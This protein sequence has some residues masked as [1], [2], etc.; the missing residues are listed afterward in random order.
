MKIVLSL[1]LLTVPI[2]A[3][4]GCP[5]RC[6]DVQ[7]ELEFPCDFYVALGQCNDDIMK[8]EVG[9]FA[10]CFCSC[11]RCVA[12][13]TVPPRPEPI[14]TFATVAAG[15]GNSAVAAGSAVSTSEVGA[16]PLKCRRQN[17]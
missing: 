3:Q 12:G 8:N 17:T 15:G 1:L 16:K 14:D 7:P 13:A 2:L 11:G 5:R 6:H 10:Y 4:T 9:E